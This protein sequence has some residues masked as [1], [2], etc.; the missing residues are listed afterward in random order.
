MSFL[1]TIVDLGRSAVN[2]FTGNSLG[3]SILKTVITGFG[4]RKLTE[5]NN[6]SQLTQA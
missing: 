1:D 6:L 2:F 5:S 4:V 3:S